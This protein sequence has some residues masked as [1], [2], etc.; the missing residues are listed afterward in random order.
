[1]WEVFFQA[2]RRTTAIRMIVLWYTQSLIFCHNIAVMCSIPTEVSPRRIFLMKSIVFQYNFAHTRPLHSAS[3]ASGF[4]FRVKSCRGQVCILK[5]TGN[6][7]L[8]NWLIDEI[9]LFLY[10]STFTRKKVFLVFFTCHTCRTKT[11]PP[12]GYCNTSAPLT[13]ARGTPTIKK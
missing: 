9:G 5:S 6:V 13:Y 11:L 10:H 3:S 4:I 2:A 8:Y 12:H 7:V 1:M